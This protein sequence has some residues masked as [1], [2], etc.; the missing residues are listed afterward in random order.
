MALELNK[1][2]FY[3]I[4]RNTLIKRISPTQVIGFDAVIDEFMANYSHVQAWREKLAYCLATFY[5]ETA[6][7]M[8]AIEEYG[9]GAGKKYG[10]R[11]KINGEKY[12]D[13]SNIFYGRGLPQLTWYDNYEKS[14]KYTPGINLVENPEAMLDIHVSAKVGIGNMMDGGFT[15]RP[16]SRYFSETRKEPY[17]AR[18]VVNGMKIDTKDENN[19]IDIPARNIEKY[20][21]K[22]LS[23]IQLYP[24]P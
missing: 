7:T 4:V 19:K 16:L 12:T 21:H 8:M 5:H 24:N 10:K 3:D 13:T 2:Y 1:V 17:F 18:K 20:Y 6:F 15:G 14:S 9:K 22:F 23:A 11:V